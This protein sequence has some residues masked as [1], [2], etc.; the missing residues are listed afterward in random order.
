MARVVHPE[1][2]QFPTVVDR[3]RIASAL[4]VV[5]GIY[6]L[7]SAW[8]RDLD[9]GHQLNAIVAGAATILLGAA[10]YWGIGGP[11]TS[12][13]IALIGAWFAVSPWVYRYAG[14][15]W[16]WHSVLVGLLIVALGSWS[17]TSPAPHDRR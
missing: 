1:R 15:N 14:E 17:A 9:I 12:W 13:T 8:V 3:V 5:A 7:T 4:S 16:M 10:R 6:M 2:A 11:W